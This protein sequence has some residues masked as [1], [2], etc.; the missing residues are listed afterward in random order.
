MR[1]LRPVSTGL[2]LSGLLLSS[3][4]FSQT[5]EEARLVSAGAVLNAF[6]TDPATAIPPQILQYAQGI[7]IFPSVIRAG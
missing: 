3:H 1:C 2:L 4:S 6:T 7:A 5:V